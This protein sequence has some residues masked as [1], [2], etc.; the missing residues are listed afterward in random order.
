MPAEATQYERVNVIIPRSLKRELVKHAK[1]TDSSLTRIM[2]LAIKDYLTTQ[3]KS[4][5]DDGR[6]K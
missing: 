5:V 1:E 2:K 4:G 6:R 3:K